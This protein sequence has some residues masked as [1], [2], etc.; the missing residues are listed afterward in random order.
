MSSSRKQ[1]ISKIA[2]FL[3][4]SVIFLCKSNPVS[5]ALMSKEIEDA[6]FISSIVIRQETLKTGSISVVRPVAVDLKIL[7]IIN[8]EG[9]KSLRGYEQWLQKN[10]K[11][12]SDDG[13]D[14]WSLPDETL[15]KKYGDCEDLA[16][17]N[18]AFLHVVGYQ[19]KTMGLLRGRGNK[20]HAICV[21][22]KCGYYLWFDNTKLNK[23]SATSMEEFG[24]YILKSHSYARLFEIDLDA[25]SQNSLSINTL[26]HQYRVK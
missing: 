3:I 6:R 23:I 15:R 12:R 24:K 9:I 22:E 1:G 8:A 10:I 11:Y 17:L 4:I 5:A 7:N 13:V 16:F 19:P 26:E 20:G 14:V 25:K 21:F 18:A 2:F